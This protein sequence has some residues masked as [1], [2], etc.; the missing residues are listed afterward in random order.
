MFFVIADMPD[1]DYPMSHAVGSVRVR[2]E[3]KMTRSYLIV[4]AWFMGSIFVGCAVSASRENR[5]YAG[6]FA[7]LSSF[8]I[9]FTLGN[10][11]MAAGQ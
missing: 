10:L 4:L 5:N 7:G 11:I 1:F 8:C 2:R 6:L 3:G 9:V